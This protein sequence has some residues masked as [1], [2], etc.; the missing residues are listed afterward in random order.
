MPY[1]K[2]NKEIQ[3]AAFKMKGMSFKDELPESSA[4]QLHDGTE[5]GTPEW[6]ETHDPETGSPLNQ[7]TA[8]PFAPVTPGVGAVMNPSGGAVGA[9]DIKAGNPNIGIT[10]TGVDSVLQYKGLKKKAKG[11]N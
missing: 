9:M 4:F 8:D 2:S 7:G 5:E 10:N 6:A 1:S 3:E 11:Y